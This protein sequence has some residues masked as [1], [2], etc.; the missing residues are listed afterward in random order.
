M[1]CLFLLAFISLGHSGRR[2][3]VAHVLSSY[4][5]FNLISDSIRSS[6]TMCAEGNS[7]SWSIVLWEVCR[8]TSSIE[9]LISG[10]YVGR[11]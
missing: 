11:R 4:K 5:V 9:V 1:G 3:V 6:Y 8:I 7:Q 2:D 10:L